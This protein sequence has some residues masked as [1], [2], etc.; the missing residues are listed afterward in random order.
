MPDFDLDGALDGIGRQEFAFSCPTGCGG[1]L[2]VEGYGNFSSRLSPE[3][4]VYA[5]CSRSN[6]RYV[7][8]YLFI[9]QSI[10]REPLAQPLAQNRQPAH[11]PVCPPEIDGERNQFLGLTVEDGG[12]AFESALSPLLFSRCCCVRS[13]H[14]WSDVYEF[15]S[16]ES[17]TD[18]EAQDAGL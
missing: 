11:C 9:G 17:D 13:W 7:A 3:G 5:K 2:I 1:A 12:D 8:T 14:H 18:E 15:V 10:N 4:R 16:L 6:H